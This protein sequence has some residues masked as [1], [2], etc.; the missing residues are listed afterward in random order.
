MIHSTFSI[1]LCLLD[2]DIEPEDQE[3][4]H[5]Y[6]QHHDHDRNGKIAHHPLE[7]LYQKYFIFKNTFRLL[8]LKYPSQMDRQKLFIKIEKKKKLK[9]RDSIFNSIPIFICIKIGILHLI[10]FQYL[11]QYSHVNHTLPLFIHVYAL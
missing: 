3:I 8:N 2:A 5:Y 1:S 10:Q 7:G 9:Y 6:T 11:F 4:E